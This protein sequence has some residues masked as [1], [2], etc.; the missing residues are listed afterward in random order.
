MPL[1]KDVVDIENIDCLYRYALMLTR[2]PPEAENLVQETYAQ[3]HGAI[4]RL[5]SDGNVKGWMFTILRNI[6]LNQLRRL[7]H[8]SSSVSTG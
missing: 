8:T 6:W 1:K 3:A 4:R 2:N 7:R 5:Q